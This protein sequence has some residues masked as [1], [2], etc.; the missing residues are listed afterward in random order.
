MQTQQLP[1]CKRLHVAETCVPL[2]AQLAE[3]SI[4]SRIACTVAGLAYHVIED[5]SGSSRVYAFAPGQQAPP[6]AIQRRFTLIK[7]KNLDL[8]EFA[9]ANKAAAGSGA[10]QVNNASHAHKYTAL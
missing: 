2:K 9:A 6:M 4:G 1:R 5:R 7:Q 10:K 8:E 3:Y